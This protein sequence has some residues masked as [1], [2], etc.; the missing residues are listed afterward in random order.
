MYSGFVNSRRRSLWVG[1]EDRFVMMLKK[2]LRGM[3][4][5]SRW[6]V[7]SVRSV[8]GETGCGIVGGGSRSTGICGFGMSLR[9]RSA[10][11]VQDCSSRRCATSSG[12]FLGRREIVSPGE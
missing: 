9:G 8:S 7:R 10:M 2:D 4:V 3:L 6:C 5:M 1:F 12:K 11:S